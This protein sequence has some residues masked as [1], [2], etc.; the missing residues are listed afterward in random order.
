MA[1]N[2]CFL[3]FILISYLASFVNLH[4]INPTEKSDLERV[5]NTIKMFDSGTH[6]LRIE[7][8]IF[9]EKK[10]VGVFLFGKI[11]QSTFHRYIA[12]P[13]CKTVSQSK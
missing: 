5:S 3:L 10:V 2:L 8:H 4:L 1:S 11:Q 9:A 12:F 13:M 7:L 6:L